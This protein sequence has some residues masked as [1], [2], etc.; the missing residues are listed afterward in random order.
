MLHASCGVHI[1]YGALCGREQD[2]NSRELL[3][4]AF[5]MSKA[6]IGLV[7]GM[8]LMRNQNRKQDLGPVG[9]NDRRAAHHCKA[10]AP[11]RIEG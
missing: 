8:P 2:S 3:S 6:P 1:K 9:A 5:M 10:Q 11:P 4:I 7:Y